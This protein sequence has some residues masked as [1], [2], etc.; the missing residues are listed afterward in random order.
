[1]SKFKAIDILTVIAKNYDEMDLRFCGS[2]NE[3]C[4]AITELK[5][6]KVKE[7]DDVKSAIILRDEPLNKKQRKERLVKAK[8]LDDEGNYDSRYFSEETVNNSRNKLKTLSN[9]KGD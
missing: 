7:L 2:Y 5:N 8:I 6:H 3:I 9:N 1:M 4:E